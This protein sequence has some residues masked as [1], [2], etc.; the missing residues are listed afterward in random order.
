MVPPLI[1]YCRKT[2][3][4]LLPLISGDSQGLAPPLLSACLYSKLTFPPFD[5]SI[6]F[7]VNVLGQEAFAIHR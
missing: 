2:A 6:E 7:E 1:E 3:S 5:T 4:G